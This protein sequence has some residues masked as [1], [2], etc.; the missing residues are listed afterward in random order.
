MIP[1]AENRTRLVFV[2]LSMQGNID[3]C[4][5]QRVPYGIPHDV[6]DRAAE[7]VLVPYDGAIVHHAAHHFA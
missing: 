4:S 5:G 2:H 1:N 7:Q 3:G 6:F